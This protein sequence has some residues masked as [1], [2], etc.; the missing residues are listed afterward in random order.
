ML[1][2][3]INFKKVKLLIQ[4]WIIKKNNSNKLKLK[5]NYYSK[6]IKNNKQFKK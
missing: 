3:L 6:T 5:K 2:N 1:K 4:L